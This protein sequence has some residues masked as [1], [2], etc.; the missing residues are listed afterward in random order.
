MNMTKETVIRIGKAINVF[1]PSSVRAG[2][3]LVSMIDQK[4][5]L[6]E[7]VMEIPET[8]EGNEL[9]VRCLRIGIKRGRKRLQP[10]LYV[11][12]YRKARIN[13]LLSRLT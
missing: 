5:I 12:W 3:I 4:W 13:Q 2:K 7:E 1:N 6:C 8:V 10:L 9:L 11:G